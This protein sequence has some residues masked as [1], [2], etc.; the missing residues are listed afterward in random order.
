MLGALGTM[1]NSIAELRG[2]VGT[3]HG[4]APDTE[5]PPAGV[6]RLAVNAAVALGVFLWETH[7]TSA[8]WRP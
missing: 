6:A 2:Q 3:G 8:G 5:A 4:G 1:T 7:E